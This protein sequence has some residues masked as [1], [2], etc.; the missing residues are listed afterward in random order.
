MNITSRQAW[1][2]LVQQPLLIREH[3]QEIYNEMASEEPLPWGYLAEK[4]LQQRALERQLAWLESGNSGE[5]R[6]VTV[7][8]SMN[9]S[10]SQDPVLNRVSR[11]E[12]YQDPALIRE[13]LLELEFEITNLD[14][15]LR[16]WNECAS[17]LSDAEQT[18]ARKIGI[19]CEEDQILQQIEWDNLLRQ[20]GWLET[21]HSGI[22][23]K[24]MVAFLY[25]Q[26]DGCFADASLHPGST[27]WP[28]S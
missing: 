18:M 4:N 12:M 1:D 8:R 17:D 27:D 14:I 19:N 15:V 23:P 3:L 11:E 22:V 5:V 9:I 2:E 16:Y 6:E 26:T 25:A 28:L 13:R 24:A 21:G 20:L 10:R 7:Y